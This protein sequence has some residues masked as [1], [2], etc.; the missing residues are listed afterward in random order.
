MSCTVNPVHNL[1]HFL[2]V[3]ELIGAKSESKVYYRTTQSPGA[4]MGTGEAETLGQW[5][6]G[7]I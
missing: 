5:F 6:V 4:G 7:F 2:A 1:V 3:E